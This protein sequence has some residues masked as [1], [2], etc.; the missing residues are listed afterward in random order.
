MVPVWL[1]EA[2]LKLKP[3]AAARFDTSLLA[4]I[5]D[6]TGMIKWRRLANDDANPGFEVLKLVGGG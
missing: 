1:A 3:S 6:D 2:K 5:N 4:V